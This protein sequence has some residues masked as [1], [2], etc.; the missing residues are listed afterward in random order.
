MAG[1]RS[2]TPS[3]PRW[4]PAVP[5]AAAGTVTNSSAA[6]SSTGNA[7]A[8]QSARQSASSGPTSIERAIPPAMKVLHRPNTRLRRD[9]AVIRWSTAGAATTTMRNPSPSTKRVPSSQ[10]KSVIDAPSRLAPPRI[11]KPMASSRRS[12]QR[13]TRM[14]AAMPPNTPTKG[15]ADMIQPSAARSPPKSC[16]SDGRAMDALPTC[17]AAA[18]PAKIRLA[19]A[20]AWVRGRAGVDGL[21]IVVAS[22]QG[23]TPGTIARRV[24]RIL[25]A[26][27]NLR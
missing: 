22:G 17:K 18:I 21:S 3:P 25:I 5:P 2:S 16:C 27:L 23:V 12:P 14:P 9:S 15:K 1:F 8:S 6:A 26:Q 19:T 10:A 4:P 7:L 24:A 11:A 13:R 20:M